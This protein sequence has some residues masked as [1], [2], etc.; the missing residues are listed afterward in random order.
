MPRLTEM[1][2]I[3]AEMASKLEAIGIDCPEKLLEI[4]AKEAFRRLK[5][6]FPNVCLVHL[7]SLEGAV[8]NTEFNALSEKKKRELKVLSDSLKEGERL[9]R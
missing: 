9:C 4:G 5:E 6:T 8:T 2:N 1:K 3:G 7:Y